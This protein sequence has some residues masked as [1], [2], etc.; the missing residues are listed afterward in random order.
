MSLVHRLLVYINYLLL[1]ENNRSLGSISTLEN[2]VQHFSISC[3]ISRDLNIH[4]KA[5]NE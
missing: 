1:I 3:L 2:T 4:V 5:G